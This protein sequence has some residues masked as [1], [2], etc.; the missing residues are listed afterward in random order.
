MN[1][2]ASVIQANETARAACESGDWSAAVASLKSDTVKQRDSTLR[3]SRWLMLE[4]SGQA[5]GM[6][7]GTT[8]ADV[9]LSTLQQSVNPRVAAA[10]QAMA[11][12]GIDLSDPQ[13]QEMLP[14]LAQA[15]AWPEG[16]VDRVQA[17][18]VTIVSKAKAETGEEP[19]ADAVQ[20]AYESS[21]VDTFDKKSV[22]LSVNRRANGKAAVS[23]RVTEIGTTA[24]GADAKGQS[25]V[26]SV[27]DSS[28]AHADAKVQALLTAINA[29][30]DSY[31]G[32]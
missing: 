13:V 17:K 19:T 30:I 31:I 5:D 25:N 6:S 16:L 32:D 18:G 1:A 15:G 7:P 9:I 8:E 28:V 26:V 29:A 22:L 24:G 10:Y 12:D 20:L 2:L 14:L 21:K 4:F 23:V 3:S 11:F 27:A